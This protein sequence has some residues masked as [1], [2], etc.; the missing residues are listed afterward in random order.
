MKKSMS[1]KDGVAISYT[2][3]GDETGFPILINHGLI[4]SIEDYDLFERLIRRGAH[5]ICIARPGYGESSPCLLRNIGAWAE[6]VE[7][8][9][10]HLQ[11]VQFDVLG[12][13]SG[14][15]YSYAVAHHCPDRVRNIYIFSGIP[16]LYEAQVQSH[17]PFPLTKNASIG[18]MQSLA[19]ELFFSNLSKQ[20]LGRN[21]IKDSMR[22]N[23][24]GI[25]QDLKIRCGDWGFNLSDI[26]QNVYMQ[27]SKTDHAV[28]FLTAKMTATLLSHCQL[29]VREDGEHFSKE[30]LND[31]IESVVMGNYQSKTAQ[32]I[33]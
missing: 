31:F 15:P 12:M 9:V 11:L 17:W 30:A 24:F 10:D 8:V 7:M 14:A 21:E 22:H 16:A 28:P 33:V 5:L 26:G 20:D 27:H 1:Y 2:D 32:N 18:E 6:L 13:S 19:R 3:F 4:A 23:C 29:S 25:A